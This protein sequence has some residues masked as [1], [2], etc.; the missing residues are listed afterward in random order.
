M[1]HPQDA[2][3]PGAICLYRLARPGHSDVILSLPAG[4]DA[5]QV[6]ASLLRA[7][8]GD[9]LLQRVDIG[10]WE[11]GQD[12]V[13]SNTPLS[14]PLDGLGVLGLAAPDRDAWRV[15]AEDG[16]QLLTVV[17]PDVSP[18]QVAMLARHDLRLPEDA[19]LKVERVGPLQK[20]PVGR[21]LNS[22]NRDARLIDA[23]GNL[24]VGLPAVA[25]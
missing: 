20:V 17:A 8:F 14:R 13:R 9:F 5:A 2:A 7:G 3:T 18:F 25:A 1:N 10:C 22:C 24:H 21:T 15:T 11:V 6:H 4:I 16:R 23:G 12:V 19:D